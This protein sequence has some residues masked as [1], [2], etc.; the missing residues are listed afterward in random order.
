MS[1]LLAT[2]EGWSSRLKRR[3]GHLQSLVACR[4]WIIEI[5]LAVRKERV[6][7]SPSGSCK[8]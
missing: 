6:A 7:R 8:A 1:T 4:Y 3:I 2:R 5:V